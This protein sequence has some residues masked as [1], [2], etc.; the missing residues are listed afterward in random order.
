MEAQSV[1]LYIVIYLLQQEHQSPHGSDTRLLLRKNWC[2]KV[3]N[4]ARSSLAKKGLMLASQR[5][6]SS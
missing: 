1:L 6:S 3:I 5:I 4:P 2:V